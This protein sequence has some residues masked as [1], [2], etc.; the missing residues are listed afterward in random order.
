MFCLIAENEFLNT[1]VCVI[2]VSRL[3]T[4]VSRKKL[5]SVRSDLELRSSKSLLLSKKSHFIF[6]M[7]YFDIM[8]YLGFIVSAFIVYR[9]MVYERKD[10]TKG[11]YTRPGECVF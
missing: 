9:L 2:N 1:L 3:I 11:H 7:D 8:E 10:K 4:V 5:F 6:T